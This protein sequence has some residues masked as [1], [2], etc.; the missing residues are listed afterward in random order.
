MTQENTR[1]MA[2]TVAREL[3]FDEIEAISGGNSFHPG[4]GST[5]TLTGCHG[6]SDGT[7]CHDA[8]ED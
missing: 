7:H 6:D 5:I 3:T 2:R 8:E 4:G 1:I